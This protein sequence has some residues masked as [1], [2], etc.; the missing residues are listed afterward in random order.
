[1]KI[2]YNVWRKHKLY[3]TPC[4]IFEFCS[5]VRLCM[6]FC[7]LLIEFEA[8]QRTKTRLSKKIKKIFLIPLLRNATF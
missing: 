5:K 1:M 7:N 6:Y 2:M 4:L 3:I 8:L